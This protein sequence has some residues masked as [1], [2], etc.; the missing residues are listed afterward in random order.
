[1]P[2]R[3][4]DGRGCFSDE[5]PHRSWRRWSGDD[6]LVNKSETGSSQQLPKDPLKVQKKGIGKRRC[7][8]ELGVKGAISAEVTP[9][10]NQAAPVGATQNKV[11]RN[12]HRDEGLKL[13]PVSL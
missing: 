5:A 2:E 11:R 10:S 9:T 13:D 3:D 8:P 6:G 7:L 1:M 4:R 12:L